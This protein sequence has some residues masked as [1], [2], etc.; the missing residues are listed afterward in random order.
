MTIEEIK[1]LINTGEKIDVEFKKSE[2]NLN[3]DIY[4]SVCSFN[5]RNGGDIF[6]GIEDG[7]KEIRGVNP[8][9]IDKMLK[10]FTTSVNNANKLNPPMYLTP[11]I[12]E[13]DGKKI[14]HI[15]IP[16]GAQIRR[17]NGRILDRTYEG[18]IDITD[19]AELVYKMYARKQ[20]TYFVNKVYPNLGLEFLDFEVIRRAKKMAILRV[21][22]H[23]W[24]DMTEEEILKSLGLIITDPDTGK[25]GITLAAILLFGKDS[26]IM[27][28]LPQ[29]K[30][31][32]IFR[33]KNLDR[34]DDR[35]VIITNLIDSYRRL[36]DFG[37]KHLNDIFV[38]DGDQSISAR[39]KILRE[40]ISNILAHRDYSNAYTAQFVIEKDKIFTKNSNLPHGHGELQLNKFEPFPKNPPISKVF[41]E[42]GYAD[43]LG[44]GMRNANKY[45]K[46]YS[47][48]TP[49]FIEDSIFEIIIPMEGAAGLQVGPD[50]VDKETDKEINI[51]TNKETSKEIKINKETDIE[52]SK[53][54]ET[55][56]ETDI[57]TDKETNKEIETS[58]ETDKEI[59]T[60]KE[61]SIET[62]KETEAG[63]ETSGKII[64]IMQESPEISI[65]EVA[66]ILDISISGVR[67]HINKM[68]KRGMLE[69]QG[70]TKKGKWIVH[71]V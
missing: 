37:K 50:I 34:Y 52:T 14:I 26:T 30:T 66:E 46:L 21:D 31:D 57:E 59:K 69:H 8:E 71:E 39:D 22:N 62:N 19:N 23:A 4:E 48:G 45:T 5:N 40:I 28:V 49:I 32:A 27:S 17:L 7:T 10:D 64:E 33:V 41:R 3:R 70:S 12:Y 9:R 53:E 43:E 6:L 1:K 15:R 58:K 44:S 63:K 13:I 38:L 20:T 24:V 54:I 42:I 67:Y 65:K 25:E 68:K 2:N 51:E 61:T 35:E 55:N 60:N 18:D 56:E 16:E 36:M 11:E 29:Y 47:G